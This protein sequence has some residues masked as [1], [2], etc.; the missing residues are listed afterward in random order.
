MKERSPTKGCR[1]MIDDRD[2][3]ERPMMMM[4]MAGIRFIGVVG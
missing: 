4:M 2:C 3:H 1:A